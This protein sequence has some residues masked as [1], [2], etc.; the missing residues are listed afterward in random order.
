MDSST[1][2]PFLSKMKY[3]FDNFMSKG[4]FSVFMAL[5]IL[6]V[7]AFA[8]MGFIRFCVNLIIPDE[9]VSE[10]NSQLWRSFL[11][12]SDAG[13]I[14]EDGDSNI[15]NKIVGIVTIGFGLV[16]FSS[17]VA[18]I[19]SQF[20]AKLDEL[21][22]GKSNVIE[23]DHTLILG[24]GD[25]VLEIIR[26][27]IIANESEKSPAIVVLSDQEKNEMDD[28]FRE[29]IEDPQNT[30]I[31]CRSGVSSSIQMLQ[32]VNICAAKSV[33]I[34]N[35]ATVDSSEEDKALADARVLKTIMAVIACTGEESLPPVVAEIHQES[36]RRL[37]RTISPSIT[38]IEEHSLL[39]KLIVQTSRVS[40]LALVYD[41]LVGFEGDEF[42][43]YSPKQ[44]WGAR[45]YGQIQFHF[46]TCS[47]I[48]YRDSE[49]QV[50]INPLP[51]TK[52]DDSFE[53]LLIAE[54]DSAIRF[55]ENAVS[56]KI[57]EGNP[58][59]QQPQRPERQLIVG[60]TK[61]SSIIVDEYASYLVEGSQIDV[62]VGTKTPEMEAEFDAVVKNRTTVSL[63]LIEED[64]HSADTV[65][66]LKPENYENVI[67]LKGDGGVAE[68]RD[69]ETIAIL[70][71]FRRYFRELGKP[72]KTQLVS[73]VADSE[74][75]E[76]IQAV[77]VKDFLISN[78]FVSKIYAQ[79]SEDPEVMKA[80][81]ELFKAEGSEIYLKPLSLYTNQ[82]GKLSF[83]DICAAA[84]KRNETCFGVRISSEENDPAKG[85][86]IYV[87]PEKS[88]VFN[89]K[90]DDYLITLAED[91]S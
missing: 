4:G 50:C 32:K 23:N 64:I 70:L 72:V 48:G 67:I 3:S 65:A 20:E 73:E 53:L 44:G 36:I 17:L 2:P 71:E 27:L 83:A 61:K 5:L 40:G 7:I 41:N 33:I 18:F 43:Y 38:T 19:T 57:P 8:L 89:L 86:G 85:H 60:W 42:Y 56:Y 26:E 34:L 11:Q 49:G 59:G 55:S 47:V 76:V 52:L 31:I 80:Y 14:A 81:D 69:S 90:P 63:R 45:T 25:R 78:K 68:L 82:S 35:D 66:K 1:K 9:T 87:N 29:R 28:Y 15:L 21:R 75:V 13:A 84:V 58:A 88:K 54:D 62:I 30:R 51:E 10:L 39:A 6:F 74:N 77:G 91:E 22:K 79:I 37:A 16:L 46:P 12:I 24:F